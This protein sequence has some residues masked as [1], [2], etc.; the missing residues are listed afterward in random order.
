MSIERAVLLL[1]GS[2]VLIALLLA[3]LVSPW[4]MLL[5]AFVGANLFQ[6]ALT[7][8][9]PAARIFAAL[10]LKHGAAFR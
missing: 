3:W 4:W 1:A 8:F 2:M 10:G 7:G 9:C 5:A 6:S